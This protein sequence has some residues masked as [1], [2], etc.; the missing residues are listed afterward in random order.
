MD[1]SFGIMIIIL[2]LAFLVVGFRFSNQIK[3]NR[4]RI[5]SIANN[6][7]Y[8]YV[9]LSKDIIPGHYEQKFPSGINWIPLQRGI[10]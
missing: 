8:T 3:D 4:N 6:L 7:E 1:K 10:K 9:D 5:D 2:S